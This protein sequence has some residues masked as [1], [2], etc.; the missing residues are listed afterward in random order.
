[1]PTR[2]D[3]VLAVCARLGF[4]NSHW[5]DRPD[6]LKASMEEFRKKYAFMH[7]VSLISHEMLDSVSASIQI[8]AVTFLE[9]GIPE[10]N[11]AAARSFWERPRGTKKILYTQHKEM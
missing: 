2:Q 3:G 1:M 8:M 10:H 4:D 6:N 11:I 7:N 5:S 9:H